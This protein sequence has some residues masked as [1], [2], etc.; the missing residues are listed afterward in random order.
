MGQRENVY[1]MVAM[2][3][4]AL[5]VPPLPVWVRLRKT[6][7]KKN[8]EAEEEEE[9]KEGYT[10]S[11]D[12]LAGLVVASMLRDRP[13]LNRKRMA[14]QQALLDELDASLRGG[15][16]GASS[17]SWDAYV[18]F[19]GQFL[20]AFGDDARAPQA[21]FGESDAVVASGDRLHVA[22][23]HWMA[24]QDIL[25]ERDPTRRRT[26]A[27]F[28]ERSYG[29]LLAEYAINY[30][31]RP[32]EEPKK[33]GDGGGEQHAVT[34]DAAGGGNSEVHGGGE[35]AEAVDAMS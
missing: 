19:T 23:T 20:L 7:T 32:P 10:S 12:L 31:A 3:I 17:S 2:Y 13:D 18:R 21:R 8:A 15:G 1:E 35:H 5:P 6:T 22:C 34:A 11:H 28:A 9:E 4:T 14:Q 16:G 30:A 33:D 24:S 29:E 26:A 27:Q 25:H